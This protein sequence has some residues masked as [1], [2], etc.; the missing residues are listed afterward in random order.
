[1][2]FQVGDYVFLKIGLMRMGTIEGRQ[3]RASG[4]V[5]YHFRLDPR[6]EEPGPPFEAWVPEEEIEYC[7][8]PSDE[9]V[10]AINKMAKLGS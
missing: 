6:F 4:I 10:R 1:M 9:Q 5:E 8:R 7:T 3:T 2:E